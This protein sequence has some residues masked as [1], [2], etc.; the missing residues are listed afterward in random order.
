MVDVYA[1]NLKTGISIRTLKKMERLGFLKTTKP[2][3]PETARMEWTLRKGNP[4]SVINLLRLIEN[5]DLIFELGEYTDKAESQV[6]A[7]GDAK[8]EA[9]QPS[10]ATVIDSAARDD[11][12]YVEA[13]AQWMMI[14]IPLGRDVPHHYLAVRAL[15]GVS[16]NLRPYLAGRIAR[17][18]QNVRE[19]PSFYGWFTFKTTRYARNATFYHRPKFEFDL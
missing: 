11:P 2:Q 19:T 1:I 18:F 13:L 14:A 7:L 8:G 9:A 15:L 4:L 16:V 5:P 10:I 12:E 6:A 17:A 3:N